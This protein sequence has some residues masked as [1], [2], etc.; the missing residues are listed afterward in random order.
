MRKL[1]LITALTASALLIF[2][3]N[4]SVNPNAPFRQRYV[5]TGI[6]RSDTNYQV[7]TLSKSYQ[8]EGGI[9]PLS[10]STDPAIV[11][12]EVN[13]WY[14]DT[15][16][17]LR[18]SAIAR[19]NTSRYTDS[20]HFYYVNNLKP[21]PNQALEIQALLP[22]GILLKSV[23]Q[24][25]NVDF[26]KF[27]DSKDNINIPPVDSNYIYIGWQPLNNVLFLPKMVITYMKKGS[28]QQFEKEVPLLYTNINGKSTPVYPSTTK[29]NFLSIDTSTITQ[30]LNEIPGHDENKT[31]F[32]IGHM[33]IT[34]CVYDQYLSTY[35]TSIQINSNGYNIQ[36]NQPDY[37]NIQGG[38][39]IFGSYV[40]TFYTLRF[41]YAYLKST[42]FNIGQ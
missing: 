42:G 34:I 28:S 22:N 31:D 4:N 12:A 37:S 32:I 36:L 9:N 1:I 8:P 39:G 17:R 35:Y 38:Y 41:T 13:I 27:F 15:L 40:K 33:K 7:V 25:P 18:D 2:S 11:G 10:D 23:T 26:T 3:C 5:L 21:L 14:R 16:Y 29:E 6:M 20:V 30:A 19:T 24:T